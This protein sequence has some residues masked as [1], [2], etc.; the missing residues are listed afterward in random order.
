VTERPVTMTQLR[1]TAS[2]LLRASDCV[3]N[4]GRLLTRDQW[5]RFCDAASDLRDMLH[6]LRVQERRDKKHA[7]RTP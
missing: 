3:S 5:A 4:D 6:D 2:E 7:R 1:R